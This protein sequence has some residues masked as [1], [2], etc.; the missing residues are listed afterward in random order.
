VNTTVSKQEIRN[1]Q[2]NKQT[3]HE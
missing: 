3:K 1:T 2:T